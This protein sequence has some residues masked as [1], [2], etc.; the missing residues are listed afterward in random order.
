MHLKHTQAHICTVQAVVKPLEKT[1]LVLCCLERAIDTPWPLLGVATGIVSSVQIYCI[2]NLTRRTGCS[3]SRGE[4]FGGLCVHWF[5]W[6][7]LTQDKFFTVIG[8]FF[9]L[10]TCISKEHR[11]YLCPE[12][13]EVCKDAIILLALRAGVLWCDVFSV[14]HLLLIGCTLSLHVVPG[15]QAGQVVQVL[16][17]HQNAWR[18]RRKT[19]EVFLCQLWC[20]WRQCLSSFLPSSANSLVPYPKPAPKRQKSIKKEVMHFIQLNVEVYSFIM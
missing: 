18:F 16:W 11:F 12:Q 13:C 6:W 14:L 10:Q 17:A 19:H 5:H 1:Y 2:R 3:I 4:E 9:W 15:Q 8:L 7:V 20:E